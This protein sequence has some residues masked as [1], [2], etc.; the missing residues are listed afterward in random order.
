MDPVDPWNY[1]VGGGPTGIA[2]GSLRVNLDNQSVE[3]YSGNNN[4]WVID[5]EKTDLLHKGNLKKAVRDIEQERELR[6]QDPT[7]EMLN[8]DPLFDK[9]WSVIKDWDIGVKEEYDGYT[10]ATGNHVRAIYDA[11]KSM[12]NK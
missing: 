11:I 9:I 7:P 2:D 4:E 10:G 12:E 3:A 1:S 5:Q 6:W 8:G